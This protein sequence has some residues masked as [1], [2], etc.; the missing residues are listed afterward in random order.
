VRVYLVNVNRWILPDR[1][2][3]LMTECGHQVAGNWLEGPYRRGLD[4]FAP[5]VIVYAPHRQKEPT[6]LR[7]IPA[8]TLREDVVKKVPTILWALYPDI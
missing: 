3:Q 5:D 7:R 2:L 1:A 8:T 6:A 4:E